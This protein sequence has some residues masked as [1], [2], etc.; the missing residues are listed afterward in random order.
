MS[1]LGLALIVNVFDASPEAGDSLGIFYGL[2][3][4]V[5]YAAIIC[6]I[7]T[8]IMHYAYFQALGQLTGQEVAVLG[9]IDPLVAVVI[10]YFL[11]HETMTFSQALGGAMILGFAFWNECK[12]SK[13]LQG[14]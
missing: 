3:A 8:V 10:S 5:F 12:G 13:D 6:L 11:L 4:A 2:L 14:A 9:Y 1:T 7:H